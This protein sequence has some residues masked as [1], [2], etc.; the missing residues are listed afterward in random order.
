MKPVETG[1]KKQVEMVKI[2]QQAKKDLIKKK[3]KKM[4]ASEGLII[5]D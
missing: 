4:L 3:I 1:I 2:H 5:Q